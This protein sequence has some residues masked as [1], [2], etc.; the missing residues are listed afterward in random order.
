VHPVASPLEKLVLRQQP[1]AI[2]R[3]AHGGLAQSDLL[4]R[5]RDMALC[6]ESVERDK[7]IEIDNG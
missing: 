4:A 5:T 1:E 7:K 3:S 6:H 2:E